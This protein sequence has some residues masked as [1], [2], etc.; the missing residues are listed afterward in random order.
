[1][2]QS[3]I[4][5]DVTQIFSI[6]KIRSRV[7]GKDFKNFKAVLFIL[8]LSLVHKENGGLGAKGFL[9]AVKNY[10]HSKTTQ[11]GLDQKGLWPSTSTY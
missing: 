5:E 3:C 10:H 7:Y 8:G 1:M 4:S 2:L 6:T 9:I 11:K